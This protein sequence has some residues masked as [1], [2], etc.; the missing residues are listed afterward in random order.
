MNIE[1]IQAIY[2]WC[3]QGNRMFKIINYNRYGWVGWE[4]RIDYYIKD[5]DTGINK[6]IENIN[7]IP[8]EIVN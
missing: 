8:E 6:I 5:F 4:N 7:D 3:Q 1:L 2:E